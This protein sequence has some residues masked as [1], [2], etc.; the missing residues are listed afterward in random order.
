VR[1]TGAKKENK[2]KTLLFFLVSILAA[3]GVTYIILKHLPFIIVGFLLLLIAA[4]IFTS[5]LT[6]IWL[7]IHLVLLPYYALRKVKP[8]EEE[9]KGIYTIEE[10]KPAKSEGERAEGVPRRTYCPQCGFEVPPDAEFC[11]NCGVKLR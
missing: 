3:L 6:A 2:K 10:V 1:A 4:L 9:S 11:P 8:R 5:A 7:L